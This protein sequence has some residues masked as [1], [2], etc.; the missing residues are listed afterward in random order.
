[1]TKSPQTDNY[2]TSTIMDFGDLIAIAML[3]GILLFILGTPVSWGA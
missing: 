3:I 1:M 2:Q